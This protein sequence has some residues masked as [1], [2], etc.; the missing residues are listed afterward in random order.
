MSIFGSIKDAIFGHH[1]AA[2]PAPAPA[3]AAAATPT[4]AAAPAPAP[5][6]APAAQPR[7]MSEDEIYG[8]L[9]ENAQK[10]GEDLNYRTSIV[11]LM[12]AMGLDSSLDARKKLAGE[13]GYTGDT[14]DSATMNIWLHEKTMHRMTTG[15]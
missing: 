6:P 3:A 8:V 7:V 4:P 2:T 15:E 14:D 11:D 10:R 9:E 12:K 13:L 1:A 5:A